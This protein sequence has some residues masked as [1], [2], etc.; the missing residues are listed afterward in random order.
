MLKFIK[1]L[2]IGVPVK[3]IPIDYKATTY[4]TIMPSSDITWE[5]W[6]M[7]KWIKK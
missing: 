2:L 6:E 4:T 1:A 5:E 7:G 3:G